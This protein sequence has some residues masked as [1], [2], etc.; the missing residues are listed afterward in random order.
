[1]I[2]RQLNVTLHLKELLIDHDSYT[3]AKIIKLSAENKKKKHHDWFGESCVGWGTKSRKT[4][5]QINES[6]FNKVENI[7]SLKISLRK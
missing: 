1:M 2:K 4:H 5:T 6:D 3:R 7:Y